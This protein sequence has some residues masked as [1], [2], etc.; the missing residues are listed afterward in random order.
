MFLALSSALILLSPRFLRGARPPGFGQRGGTYRDDT[1]TFEPLCGPGR[2]VAARRTGGVG[3]GGVAPASQVVGVRAD[4]GGIA[5]RLRQPEAG[6]TPQ[7]EVRRAPASS[8]LR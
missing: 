3:V 4:G 2:A 6:L 1:V 5:A 8:M 7:R